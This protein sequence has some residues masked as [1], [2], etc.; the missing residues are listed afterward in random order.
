VHADD[1]VRA[2]RVVFVRQQSDGSLDK[3]DFY[4]SDW[5]GE[6]ADTARRTLGNGTT[7]VL[8]V[9]GRR[10]ALIDAIGLVLAE[11]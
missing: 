9:C 8:G 2:V 5:I 4:L 3:T 1:L 10:G 6:P 7:P 11:P